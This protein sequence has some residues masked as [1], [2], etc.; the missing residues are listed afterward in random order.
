MTNFT[1]KSQIG[2]PKFGGVWHLNLNFWGVWTPTVAAPLPQSHCPESLAD[3]SSSHWIWF[4]WIPKLVAGKSGGRVPQAPFPVALPLKARCA[5]G[6]VLNSP[7]IRGWPR[8]FTLQETW[9]GLAPHTFP[10]LLI[11]SRSE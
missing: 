9:S 5:N 4:G 6:A 10:Y 1:Y 7:Y 2:R 11:F 8:L 3:F